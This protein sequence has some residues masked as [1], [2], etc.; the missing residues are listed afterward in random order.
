MSSITQYINLYRDNEATVNSRSAELMNTLRSGALKTLEGRRLPEKGDEGF[1]KTSIEKMF[2]PDFGVNIN[3]IN[4]PTDIARTFKCDVPNV[5]TLLGIVVNDS[6]IAT[7]TLTKNLPEG[8]TVTSIARAATEIPDVVKR[9][10]GH[11]APDD[12]PAVALN[13]LLAQDGVV[14]RIAKNIK[15]DHPIQIVNIFNSAMPMMGVRR[16]L[17]IAEENSKASILFCDHTQTP[18]VEFLSSEVIEIAMDNNSRL[19][20]CTIEESSPLTSRYSQMFARQNA[21]S[22]LRVNNSTLLNG[23][24]RNDFTI[25]IEGE[26]CTTLLSGMVVADRKMHV[27]NSSNV[28]HLAPHS[29]SNQLFK[30][31]LDDEAEGA[32][33]GGIYVDPKA[34]FTEGFQSN[35]NIVASEKARMHTKPQL[36][37]Y[38]DDVKCS[39]GATIGQLDR[40]AMFYMQTRGIPEAT[41]KRLLMQAFMT[42]ALDTIAVEGIRSRLAMLVEKRLSG[43]NTLCGECSRDCPNN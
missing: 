31:L 20:I 37:I 42:D 35:R 4:V 17:V 33:E 14:I 34:P 22:T 6:F 8:V 2:A 26:N 9:Y 1:E 3:R 36:L 28:N 21:N 24:T 15:L 32:F 19:D 23:V 18:D 29:F 39:H 27:D 41:A 16:V 5:S 40:E 12:N 43:E 25:D 30:Y 7:S 10:Y 13:T 38:N 11:I